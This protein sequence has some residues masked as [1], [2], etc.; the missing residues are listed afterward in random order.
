MALGCGRARPSDAGQFPVVLGGGHEVAFGTY[1]GLARISRSAHPG[2]RIGI[3][4]LDAH[5]DLR[6]GPVPSSGTPF[7]QIAEHEHGRAPHCSTR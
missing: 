2:D 4:N 7:R 3:L 5:F 1:L 6:P